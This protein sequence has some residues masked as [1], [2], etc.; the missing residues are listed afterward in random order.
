MCLR[1]DD[2]CVMSFKGLS[3]NMGGAGD[4]L[5]VRW[6]RRVIR[7]QKPWVVALQETKLRAVNRELIRQL[8]GNRQCS[9]VHLPSEGASGGFLTIWDESKVELVDHLEG[10]F[11]LSTLFRNVSDNV[12]WA[13]SNIY[14]PVDSHLKQDFWLELS[15]LGGIW[16]DM[17]WCV[18]GDYNATKSREDRNTGKLNRNEAKEF[19]NWIDSFEL[20]EFELLEGLYTHKNTRGSMSRLDR[21]FITSQFAD[22]FANLTERAG[23]YYK[24]DHRVVLLASMKVTLG[25]RPF[26]CENYWLTDGKVL[27]LM[28]QWWR[29]SAINGEPGYV[30]AKKIGMWKLNLTSWAKRNCGSVELEVA[31]HEETTIAWN[32]MEEETGLTEDEGA[33]KRKAEE[34]LNLAL[35]NMESFWSQRTRKTWAVKG[36]R[37]T[38]LFHKI[39]NASAQSGYIDGLKINDRWETDLEVCKEEAMNFFRQL[40]Q[41]SDWDRPKLDGL[42]FNRLD[43]SQKRRLEEVFSES[44][45]VQA[46]KQLAKEKSPGPDGFQ[47]AVYLNC[48]EVCKDDL[49]KVLR[50]FY[51]RGFLSW[52]LNTGFITLIPKMKGQKGI[53]DFRPIVLMH[54]VGKIISKI[55]ALRLASV[56]NGLVSDHQTAGC[57]GRVIHDTIL[58]ANELVDSKKRSKSEGLLVKADFFKAFDTVSWGY[59]DYMLGRMGFG[60]KWRGWIKT[61]LGTTQLSILWNGSPTKQFRTSRGLRQG[62]PLSPL[63]FTLANEGLT[64]LVLNAQREGLVRGMAVNQ[65]AENIPLLQYADDTLFFLEIPAQHSNLLCIMEWYGAVSGL[66]MNKRKTMIY[67]IN[68]VGNLHAIKDEWQCGTDFLPT[69]YLGAPLGAGFKCREFWDETVERIRSKLGIWKRRFLSKAGRLVLIKSTLAAIPVYLMSLFKA[70]ASVIKVIEQTARRFLWGTSKEADVCK[71]HLISWEKV[72]APVHLGGLGIRRLALMNQALELKWLWR[73]RQGENQMWKRLICDKYKYCPSTRRTVRNPPTHGSCL[74]KGISR[75]WQLMEN[76][77][78]VKT[79][80]GNMARFWHDRWINGEELT[81]KEAFPNIFLRNGNRDGLVEEFYSVVQGN[82]TWALHQR[83]EQQDWQVAEMEHLNHLLNNSGIEVNRLDRLCWGN[84]KLQ[85]T[86]SEAYEILFSNTSTLQSLHIQDFPSKAVWRKAAPPK[87]CFLVWEVMRNGIATLDRLQVRG[88]HMANRCVMCKCAAESVLHLFCQCPFASMVWAI[89]LD[90]FVR[91]VHSDRSVREILAIKH[92]KPLSRIGRTMWKSVK[93]VVMWGIWVE[94]NRRIFQEKTSSL[95]QIICNIKCLLWDCIRYET[96][97]QGY[98][99]EQLIFNWDVVVGQCHL[100]ILM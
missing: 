76:Y 27:Q 38:N 17:C 79:G 12:S 59:L 84:N 28:K 49:M 99:L 35:K 67:P 55:L 2:G 90:P 45:V 16:S 88:F 81:L 91:G 24:S 47:T 80:K 8:W 56:M 31:K 82:V 13:M 72:T 10:S 7:K 54:G 60:N 86:V 42:V 87:M 4:K 40:Y 100:G 21:F 66:V 20:Q 34:S 43:E 22:L 73:F 48:W 96:E 92:S 3:W 37:C 75:H 52:R 50:D 78:T 33:A 6:L 64:Q 18:C 70:P 58:M 53:V 69:K 94:R 68:S 61:I 25:P 95:D 65:N 14:G 1:M 29:T 15:S 44:E 98:Y 93:Q 36:D 63:L 11:S 83:R 85:F 89:I 97:A 32:K 39:A 62:D 30:L 46:M 23:P 74:W 57:P 71:L 41:E 9:W 26:K 51:A 77:L 5:K 19:C